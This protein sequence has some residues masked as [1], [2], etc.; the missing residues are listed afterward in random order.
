MKV[1]IPHWN[2]R[3]SPVFDVARHVLVVE[4]NEGVEEARW[5]VEFNVEDPR[6]RAGRLTEVGANVLVCG[7]ISWSLEMAVSAAGIRV[8]P[9]ICGDVP[10]VL[11]AFIDGRLG[12]DTFLM[13]GCCRGGRR[14]RSRRRRGRW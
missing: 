2:G 3:V 11:T 7:A 4:V 1:A 14:F 8:I 13:P 12:Q 5:D 6:R 10:R 9:Q